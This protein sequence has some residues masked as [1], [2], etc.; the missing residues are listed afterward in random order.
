MRHPASRKQERNPLHQPPRASNSRMRS[1]RGAPRQPRD[2]PPPDETGLIAQPVQFRDGGRGGARTVSSGCHGEPPF[3]WGDSTPEFR[4]HSG[5][6]RDER[7]GKERCFSSGSPGTKHRAVRT[8][9]G[10]HRAQPTLAKL[11][12]QRCQAENAGGAHITRE[13]AEATAQSTEPLEF[14][15]CLCEDSRL[16]GNEPSSWSMR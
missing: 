11:P 8:L 15:S 13:E 2:A 9:G 4:S 5:G 14:Q 3:Y 1:T 7:C 6:L 16:L 10:I 12:P